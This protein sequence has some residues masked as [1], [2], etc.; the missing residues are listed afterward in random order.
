MEPTVSKSPVASDPLPP[1]AKDVDP[2]RI[3]VQQM[4]NYFALKPEVKT[5]GAAIAFAVIAALC[6]LCGTIGAVSTNNSGSIAGVLLFVLI[7]GGIA[8]A[9]WYFATSPIRAYNSRDTITDRAFDAWVGMKQQEAKAKAIE[10][11]YLDPKTFN[12]N[13]D[14]LLD[15]TAD[16]SHQVSAGEPLQITAYATENVSVK[17]PIDPEKWDIGVARRGADGQ[18]RARVVIFYWFF[19]LDSQVGVYDTQLD[20]TVNVGGVASTTD[21][22]QKYSYTGV[23]GLRTRRAEASIFGFQATL[24]SFTLALENG[25]DVTATYD[26]APQTQGDARK[27]IV[28]RTD[29]IIRALDNYI[30]EKRQQFSRGGY[31]PPP[32]YAP[33]PPGY[34]PPGYV[35]PGYVPAPPPGYV[36]PGYVPAPPGYVPQTPA[37]DSTAVPPGYVPEPPPVPPVDP[38]GSDT[39]PSGDATA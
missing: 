32:G 34:V 39:P 27:E 36:P 30:Q 12:P 26:I 6:G 28:K 35:P 24:A 22:A 15:P 31:Y 16:A 20:A 5:P 1:T 33:P 3:T 29:D 9:I 17:P 2:Y 7:F 19:T 11:L 18:L 25:H 23:T 14:A 4:R 10:R 21:E 37:P 8:A 38:P 13:P